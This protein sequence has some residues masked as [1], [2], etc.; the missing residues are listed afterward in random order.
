M[1]LLKHLLHF[2]GGLSSVVYATAVPKR[3]R[4]HF[5]SCKFFNLL[6]GIFPLFL[7]CR[8]TSI[9]SQRR[10]LGSAQHLVWVQGPHSRGFPPSVSRHVAIGLVSCKHLLEVCIQTRRFYLKLNKAKWATPQPLPILDLIVK[11]LETMKLIKKQET[12]KI[13]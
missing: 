2:F 1:R 6:K 5:V 7:C 8:S 13:I 11:N 4:C 10:G 9:P 12:I 3:H